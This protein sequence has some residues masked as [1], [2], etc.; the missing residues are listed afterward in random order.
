MDE[1]TQKNQSIFSY[2]QSLGRMKKTLFLRKVAKK[3]GVC[4][5][6]VRNWIFGNCRPLS[7][8][9]VDILSQESGVP[10]ENLFNWNLDDEEC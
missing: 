9:F 2:Y 6:T 3:C 10:V 4:N 8:H 1:M 5:M 7:D